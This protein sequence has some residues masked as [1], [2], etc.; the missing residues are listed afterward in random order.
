[1][2]QDNGYDGAKAQSQRDARMTSELTV[3]DVTDTFIA[4]AQDFENFDPDNFEEQENP[5]DSENAASACSDESDTSSE[6]SSLDEMALIY[7]EL[8]DI[9]S[10]LDESTLLEPALQVDGAAPA[11]DKEESVHGETASRDQA[12]D[13]TASL[14][15][16]SVSTSKTSTSWVPS[17]SPEKL[18]EEVGI[19]LTFTLYVGKDGSITRIE[20]ENRHQRYQYSIS[21]KPQQTLDRQSLRT[22]VEVLQ[23][24]QVY[25]AAMMKFLTGITDVMCTEPKFK[26]LPVALREGVSQIVHE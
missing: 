8:E 15:E 1:M 4:F 16:D 17:P 18:P 7:A 3:G 12:M 10:G 5:E 6:V 13:E 14:S 22:F 20:T 19:P 2:A 21:L 23:K 11:M 26:W 9:E 24:E 25:E